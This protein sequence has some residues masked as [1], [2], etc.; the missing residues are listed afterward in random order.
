MR[1]PRYSSEPHVSQTRFH[2]RKPWCSPFPLS[3]NL[4]DA[5]AGMKKWIIIH[6]ALH[7][8]VKVGSK[9]QILLDHVVVVLTLFQ[10]LY[11]IASWAWW[12]FRVIM[13]A[14]RP[15]ITIWS[16]IQRIGFRLL[17]I[18]EDVRVLDHLRLNSVQ[19]SLL[20]YYLNC[21][22]TVFGLLVLA[23]G[24]SLTFMLRSRFI[25]VFSQSNE[26]VD[27]QQLKYLKSW[28]MKTNNNAVSNNY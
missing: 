10:I 17:S 27:S 22:Q 16:T 11:S 23:G 24:Y 4:Y 7:L 1:F 15:K 14:M 28:I 3:K 5:P 9:Y 8:I 20:S 2:Y 26:T 25:Y 21:K 13:L 18:L 12:A 6:I 19:L